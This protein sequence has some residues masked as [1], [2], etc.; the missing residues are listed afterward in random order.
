MATLTSSIR[1]KNSLHKVEGKIKSVIYE[2][3]D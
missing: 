3:D 1:E 2:L